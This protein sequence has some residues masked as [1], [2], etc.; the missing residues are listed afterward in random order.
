VSLSAGTPDKDQDVFELTLLL[1]R[2]ITLACR[3]HHDVVLENLAL[4]HQL[5]TLQRR[6]WRALRRD[7]DDALPFDDVVCEVPTL[8][9]V[10]TPRRFIAV[11]LEWA[12]SLSVR[13][14]SEL[15]SYDLL[16]DVPIEREVGDDLLQFRVFVPQHLAQ[17]GEAQ[18]RVLLFHRSIDFHFPLY[19]FPGFGS[20]L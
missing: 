4:R 14:A 17:L 5:R 8:D 18:T 6:C 12:R 9:R 20:L 16:E 13:E 7:R 3:G 15:F 2:A 19:R 1:L 10:K 11:T